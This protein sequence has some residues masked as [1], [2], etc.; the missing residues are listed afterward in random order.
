MLWS[1]LHSAADGDYEIIVVDEN[2]A[3]VLADNELHSSG[4][5]SI[6]VTTTILIFPT[7]HLFTYP[8]DQIS[9]SIILRARLSL[10]VNRIKLI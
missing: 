4:P 3:P 2:N 8:F 10:S 5:A 6:K 7:S 9:N 1:Y